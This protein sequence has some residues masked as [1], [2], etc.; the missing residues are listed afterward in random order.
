MATI[1]L[2]LRTAEAA[3]RRQASYPW[4]TI[5]LGARHRPTDLDEPSRALSMSA[6]CAK[7]GFAAKKV[8]KSEDRHRVNTCTQHA[9]GF[10]L[11]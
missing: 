4:S 2:R 1:A 10:G 6:R 8:R 11:L 5:Q 9:V 7:D 3:E